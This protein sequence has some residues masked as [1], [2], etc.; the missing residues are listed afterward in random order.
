[1]MID[2]EKEV[3]ERVASY[4]DEKELKKDQN[5]ADKQHALDN[6][7]LIPRLLPACQ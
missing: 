4:I 2:F 7:A 1:M 5:L 6:L 3:E